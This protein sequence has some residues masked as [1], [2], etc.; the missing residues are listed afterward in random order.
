MGSASDVRAGGAFVEVWGDLGPLRQGLARGRKMMQDWGRSLAMGG[1]IMAGI[2]AAMAAPLKKALDLFGIQ[3]SAEAKLTAV[4][5]STGHAAGMT[6]DELKKMAIAL[7]QVTTYGDEEIINAQAML[8]T[9]KQIGKQTF[10]EATEAILNMATIMGTDLKSAAI[11]VGKA[12][13]DP[14]YGLSMLNRVG[15]QFSDSQKETIQTLWKMG[16]TAEAQS[17]ILKELNSQFG[18]QARAQLETYP[19]LIQSIKNAWGDMME[20]VGAAIRP[21]RDFLES[22]K[23][24]IIVLKEWIA[25]HPEVVKAFAAVATALLVLGTVVAAVGIAMMLITSPLVW[26]VG[27]FLVL[28]L[29]VL[30]A[31]EQFGV[32]DVGFQDFLAGFRVGTQSMLGW[33]KILTGNLYA[34]WTD[35]KAGFLSGLASLSKSFWGAISQWSTWLAKLADKVGLEDMAERLREFGANMEGFEPYKDTIDKLREDSRRAHE[36]VFDMAADDQENLL[37][38]EAKKFKVKAGF[39]GLFT[40]PE[41]PKLPKGDDLKSGVIANLGGANLAE[42]MGQIGLKTVDREQLDVM[43]SMDSTL[44]KVAKNTES[45]IVATLG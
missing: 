8:L 14:F 24:Q 27:M 34:F 44:K 40:T 11:Q 9:F 39:P 32:L 18:G 2:G 17:L 45:E 38:K 1:G 31:A 10:P 37:A 3:E 12:L 29:A 21:S 19:G 13:N 36:S 33:W 4:L 26:I 22:I 35:F 25:A 30:N 15:V 42:R 41:T 23:A 16:R 28:G 7:Q 20:A 5:E 43:K 6:A